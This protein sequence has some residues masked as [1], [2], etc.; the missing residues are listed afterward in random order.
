MPWPP[1]QRDS[2]PQWATPPADE[3]PRTATR[4]APSPSLPQSA[5]VRD[6][7]RSRLAER[8]VQARLRVFLRDRTPQ[9]LDELEADPRAHDS[10]RGA[11]QARP[12]G[13]RA[14]ANAT[15]ESP[16]AQ[17][18]HGLPV[19]EERARQGFGRVAGPLRR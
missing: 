1:P 16:S 3:V 11:E 6:M 10:D 13:Q 7:Q 14:R 19:H 17:R 5:R 18:G 8:T 9:S 2:V 4:F 12:T 15:L